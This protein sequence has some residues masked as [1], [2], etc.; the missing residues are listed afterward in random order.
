MHELTVKVSLHEFLTRMYTHGFATFH[1]SL[2]VSHAL[3]TESWN[4]LPTLCT[5]SMYFS[6]K[7]ETN[8]RSL[9]CERNNNS[10]V[11]FNEDWI[12]NTILGANHIGRIIIIIIIL[13]MCYL[14][15]V[16]EAF[17]FQMIVKFVFVFFV[18]LFFLQHFVFLSRWVRLD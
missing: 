10:I 1:A 6:V 11:Q 8:R 3:V 7:Q 15:K 5:L 9:M 12:F 2:D 18:C 4:L 13:R 17:A 14:L 16:N